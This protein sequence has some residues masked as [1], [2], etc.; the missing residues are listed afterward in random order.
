MGDRSLLLTNSVEVLAISL[1]SSACPSYFV[2]FALTITTMALCAAEITAGKKI[3]YKRI[4][5]VER[6]HGSCMQLVIM[7][8]H[9]IILACYL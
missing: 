7:H 3:N 4:D 5:N 1:L 2:C 8:N 9:I 6:M